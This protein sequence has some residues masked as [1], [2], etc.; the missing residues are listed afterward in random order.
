MAVAEVHPSAEELEAFTLGPLA[1][2]PQAYIEAHVVACTSCQ[3]RAAVAPGDTLVALLRSV[4]AR[5]SRGADTFAETAAQMQTPAP[6]AAAAETEGLA[7][8]VPPSALAG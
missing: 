2:E 6:L 1:G 3:E 4:H 7:P 8:A 5:M